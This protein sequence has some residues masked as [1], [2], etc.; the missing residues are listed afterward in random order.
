[1]KSKFI[2]GTE[3]PAILSRV[4]AGEVRLYWIVVDDCDPGSYEAFKEVL[5]VQA[6]N[7]GRPLNGM[8]DDQWEAELRTV[9]AT[10]VGAISND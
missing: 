8:A 6:V 1:M 4:R 10:I 2:M 5:R 3:L 7:I 9:C